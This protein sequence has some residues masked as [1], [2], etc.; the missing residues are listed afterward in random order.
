MQIFI[1]VPHANK[2]ISFN[3]NRTF[4]IYLN[5]GTNYLSIV[6]TLKEGYG[7]CILVNIGTS[8]VASYYGYYE[9]EYR[10]NQKLQDV[11]FEVNIVDVE[12]FMEKHTSEYYT[13]E[14]NVPK[15]KE[16]KRVDYSNG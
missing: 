2:F 11:S 5:K 12:N 9:D 6:A 4:D 3:F 14:V 1:V 10:V 16:Y 15:K 7:N 13:Y 8:G